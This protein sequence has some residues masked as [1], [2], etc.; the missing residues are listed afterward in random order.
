M[1]ANDLRELLD[2]SAPLAEMSS[3]MA[4]VPEWGELVDAVSARPANVRAAVPHI[5]AA[6]A[7]IMAGDLQKSA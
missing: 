6:I 3:V 2:E 1:I 5:K 4:A 7:A